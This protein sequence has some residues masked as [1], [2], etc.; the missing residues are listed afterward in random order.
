MKAELVK[1]QLGFREDNPKRGLI[2]EYL[3]RDFPHD[4]AEMNMSERRDFLE[5]GEDNYSDKMVKKNRVCAAEIWCEVLGRKLG[6]MRQSDTREINDILRTIDGW[7]EKSTVRFGKIYG[8]QRG[9]ARIVSK[10]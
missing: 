10:D 4:W 9:Y 1:V 7:E 3:N 8:R 6:D 2:I 5:G